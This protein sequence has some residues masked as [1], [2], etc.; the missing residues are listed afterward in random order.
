MT[1]SHLDY[2]AVEE[3]AA[4]LCCESGTHWLR[5]RRKVKAKYRAMAR[6]VI[7]GAIAVMKG[8]K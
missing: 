7:D 6:R 5:A 2:L 4:R 8:R 3:L 1:T